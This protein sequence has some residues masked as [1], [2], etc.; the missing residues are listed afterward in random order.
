MEADENAQLYSG[1]SVNVYFNYSNMR[2]GD[3]TDF[4]SEKSA[5][6]KSFGSGEGR[7]SFGGG[8][9]E[10]FDP[11]NMPDFSRRKED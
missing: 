3:F 1:Q 2:N 6:G 5:D 4:K 7:P 9:P 10:G 11:S 8:M